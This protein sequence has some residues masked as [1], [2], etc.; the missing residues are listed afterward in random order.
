MHHQNDAGMDANGE[1]WGGPKPLEYSEP[2]ATL[3]SLKYMHVENITVAIDSKK[4]STPSISADSRSAA[5]T[6]ERLSAAAEAGI[7][8]KILANRMIRTSRVAPRLCDSKTSPL[9]SRPRSTKYGTKAT[10]SN[11]FEGAQTN[12]AGFDDVSS[13]PPYSAV[14]NAML[15]TSMPLK[16]ACSL[17]PDHR[18]M[19]EST[20]DTVDNK[21]TRMET[22]AK[23][24]ACMHNQRACETFWSSLRTTLLYSGFPSVQW[25]C[26]RQLTPT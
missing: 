26:A 6:M 13:R 5:N 12:A 10:K 18:G 15:T 20:N 17:L 3:F 14:K 1:P 22:T 24:L 21:M 23:R 16:M 8:R 2:L 7:R 11:R 4:T 25:T 9:F 19:V